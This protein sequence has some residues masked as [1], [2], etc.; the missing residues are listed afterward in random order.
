MRSTCGLAGTCD[1]QRKQKS[2]KVSHCV[3]KNLYFV[4]I[5][6]CFISLPSSL[7]SSSIFYHTSFKFMVI[8]LQQSV[9]GSCKMGTL[10]QL[11]ST[12]VRIRLNCYYKRIQRYS[13]LRKQAL[14]FSFNRPEE[15]SCHWGSCSPCDHSEHQIPSLVLLV[16]PWA[17]WNHLHG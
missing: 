10:S 2:E 9:L 14:F 11:I 7:I 6:Y 8:L 4:T 17:H 16:C 15:S 1:F 13:V 3:T 5:S 12:L